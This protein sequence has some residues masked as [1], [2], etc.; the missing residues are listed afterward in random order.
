[1]FDAFNAVNSIKLPTGPSDASGKANLM[2]EKRAGTSS[3]GTGLP[4]TYSGSVENINPNDADIVWSAGASRWQVTFDVTGFSGFWVKTGGII[5]PVKWI[6]FKG[7]ITEGQHVRLD[8]KVAE[9]EVS[10]YEI[11]KSTDAVSF[12]KIGTVPAQGDGLNSYHFTDELLTQKAYYRIKQIDN[13]GTFSYSAI[14]LI[15]NKQDNKVTLYPNPVIDN[16][17]I[18]GIDAG[19]AIQLYNSVGKKIGTYIC[20]SNNEIISLANLSTGIYYI[21]AGNAGTYKVI[22]K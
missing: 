17:F 16:L 6:S 2:V 9:Y 21:Q 15:Q 14:I 18:T 22:K 13:S 5:I 19:T 8:W 20:N 7:S 3:N 12:T 1:E 4:A 10:G 11:E